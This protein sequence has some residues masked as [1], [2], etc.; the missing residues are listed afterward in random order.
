MEMEFDEMEIDE[1]QEE[2]AEIR[3]ETSE[4][5]ETEEVEELGLSEVEIALM[6]NPKDR[7]WR[8]AELVD[9]YRHPSYQAQLSFAIDP[10]T[11]EALR[12]ADGA[13]I[14][15]S[16]NVKH[17]QSPDGFYE[18]EFGGIHIREVKDYEKPDD[19]IGAISKQTFQRRKAFGHDIDLTFSLS[20]KFTIHEAQQIQ[21]FANKYLKVEIDYQLK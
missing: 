4:I 17:C 11:G 1:I 19:V 8:E 6:K 12:D 14:H 20:P 5:Q 16:R 21:E 9:I 15:C 2:T 3:D 13:W 7:S 18:D 10:D